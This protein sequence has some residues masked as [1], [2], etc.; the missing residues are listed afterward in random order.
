VNDSPNHGTSVLKL[1]TAASKPLENPQSE[2]QTLFELF[3][4]A[5]P[6]GVLVVDSEGLIK[7]VN[8]RT[9]KMFGYSRSELQGQP[10]ELLVPDRFRKAHTQDRSKYQGAPVM[11]PMGAHWNC[12]A[13]AVTAVNFPSRL[14]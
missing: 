11:R 3:F 8:S 6:D 9:E 1:G 5:S 10:V 13:S 4:E 14:C 7:L 12:L 2:T